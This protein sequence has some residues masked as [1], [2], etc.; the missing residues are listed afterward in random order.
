MSNSFSNQHLTH[1]PDDGTG[2]TAGLLE[3]FAA[4]SDR[5]TPEKESS[6]RVRE[7]AATPENILFYVPT[8]HMDDTQYEGHGFMPHLVKRS[9]MSLDI[10][11]VPVKQT[12]TERHFKMSSHF[13]YEAALVD[14]FNVVHQPDYVIGGFETDDDKLPGIVLPMPDFGFDQVLVR[15]DEN[16]QIYREN[17][18]Y[19]GTIF[20]R[21][22]LID[23][24]ADKEMVATPRVATLNKSLAM[25]GANWESELAATIGAPAFA[26][27]VLDN[28]QYYEHLGMFANYQGSLQFGEDFHDTKQ[29]S[30]EKLRLQDYN[31]QLKGNSG[32][33]M[34]PPRISM[35]NF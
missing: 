10:G 7:S 4:F 29:D 9:F 20:H 23:H 12:I 26:K 15:L 8:L 18:G 30:Y 33:W 11:Y 34:N 25:M 24:L 1:T 3:R 6:A 14:L 31:D 17:N 32:N 21:Y 2:V 16:W 5:I 19:V 22:F 13:M 27:D 28:A 35:S